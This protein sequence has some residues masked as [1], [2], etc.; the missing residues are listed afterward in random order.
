MWELDCKEGKMTKNWCLQTVVLEKIPEN[1]LGGKE[2]KPVNLKGDQPWIYTGRT[3]AEVP[4][5]WSPDVNRQLIG[6]IPD[7]GKDRQQKKRASEDE[8]AGRHHW[9]NESELGQTQG[10][11]EGQAGLECYSPW[12]HRVTHNWAT[13]QQQHQQPISEIKQLFEKVIWVPQRLS[14]T[15]VAKP[16][17]EFRLSCSKSSPHTIASQ[18]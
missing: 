10:D 14:L 2:I 11:G 18:L 7:I 6:K 3:D 17:L 1:L 9:C 12:G 4:V 8:M 13:E 5:F 16:G 15:K